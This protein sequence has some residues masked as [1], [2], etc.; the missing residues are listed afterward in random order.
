MDS[1]AN[2][3]APF[4]RFRHGFASTRLAHREKIKLLRATA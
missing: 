3:L 4:S 1:V 2:V